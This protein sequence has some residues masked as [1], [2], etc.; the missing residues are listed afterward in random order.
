MKNKI[1]WRKPSNEVLSA[2]QR[3]YI[4]KVPAGDL[5]GILYSNGQITLQL[6][7]N[8]SK[9]E[10]SYVYAMGKWNIAEIL[11]HIIDTER[12]FAYR[13]LRI[14]R[15][16]KTPLPGYEQNDYIQNCNANERDFKEILEEFDSVR[17]ATISLFKSFTN[18]MLKNSGVS[19]N[20]DLTVNEIAYML[21]GHEM[22]HIE[23]IRKKYLIQ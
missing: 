9:E 12:I 8:I 3:T 15:G 5:I 11:V 4:D 10:R 16:D 1:V 20:M 21:A 18:E 13:A 23:V 6:L 17:K 14:A 2:Y 7:Q 22:H 19:N